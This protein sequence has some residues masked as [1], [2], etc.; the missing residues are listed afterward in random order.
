MDH[1]FM[2]SENGLTSDHHRLFLILWDKVNLKRSDQVISN[3][4]IY[5]TW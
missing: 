4:S 3:L 5:Y 2:N 1:I